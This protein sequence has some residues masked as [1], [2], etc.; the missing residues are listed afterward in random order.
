ML[1]KTH[2]LVLSAPVVSVSSSV[3]RRAITRVNRDEG[4]MKRL[5]GA[6]P[7]PTTEC[8]LALYSRFGMAGFIDG[9]RKQGIYSNSVDII[10]S[11]PPLPSTSLRE[12]A[13]APWYAAV[14]RCGEGS[15]DL[16]EAQ[17]LS[18]PTHPIVGSGWWMV[19]KKQ[20][21]RRS[22]LPPPSCGEFWVALD[23]LGAHFVACFLGLEFGRRR[24]CSL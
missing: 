6:V 2:R 14:C 16:R 11:A 21:G 1:R 4:E 10:L 20:K 24:R 12:F 17:F 23:G 7:L 9:G 22:R 19:V 3:T 13:I 18:F 5:R 8:G 15:G